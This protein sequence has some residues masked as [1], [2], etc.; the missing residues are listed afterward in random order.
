MP[1]PDVAGMSALLQELLDHPEG[2]PETVGN[3]E[4][5]ALVPVVGGQDSLAEIQGECSHAQTLP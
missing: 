3:L 4:P 2:H 1:W 5:R